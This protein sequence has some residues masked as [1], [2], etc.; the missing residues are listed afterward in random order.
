MSLYY[1]NE[2]LTEEEIGSVFALGSATSPVVSAGL[3]FLADRLAASRGPAARLHIFTACIVWGTLIFSLQGLSWPGVPRLW[4]MLVGRVLLD[5][6]RPATF[7]ILDSITVQ[8][9]SDRKLYGQERLYGAY[10]WAIV[11][12]CLGAL[13]DRFGPRVMH[14][15]LPVA[16]MGVLAAVF[17]AGPPP[18]LPQAAVGASGS[19]TCGGPADAALPAQRASG[20]ALRQLFWAY[21]SSP[22]KVAF[23]L[24][25]VTL[26]VGM[27][28]VENLLFLYFRQLNASC[29]VCGLSVV[30]TVVFEIPLFARSKTLLSTFGSRGCLVVAGLCYSIRVV[31]YT[32]VP[33]GA[34]VLLFE[35][36]HGVTYAFWQT[37]SVEVMASIT[38]RELAT[39]GQNFLSAIRTFCGITTG[40]VLGGLI[41]QTFGQ[42]VLYRGAAVLVAAGLAVFLL[43]N[44]RP[45]VQSE[46][47]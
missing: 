34:W 37:A 22:A 36:M 16:A 8:A 9:L 23:F 21:I 28:L 39:T 30:V 27:T 43:A 46:P 33:G 41:M 6:A 40:N 17:Y 31:G 38:P 3:S 42:A 5:V 32:L 18:S 47:P 11:G 10:S 44:R 2:G 7:S 4:V 24:Y 35:P 13:M 14:P 20:A 19:L 45:R 12:V 15:C 1:Q 25:A 26:G 29:F